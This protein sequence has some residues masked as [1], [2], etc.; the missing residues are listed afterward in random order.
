VFR[1]AAD[2][3]SHCLPVLGLN[4]RGPVAGSTKILSKLMY[5]SISQPHGAA[6]EHQERATKTRESTAA[7]MS[8][9]NCEA[10]RAGARVAAKTTRAASNQSGMRRGSP[11]NPAARLPS[12]SRTWRGREIVTT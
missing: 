12:L 11:M 9:P 2:K 6:R 8:L 3:G 4:V 10:Q 5:G 7:R 1:K